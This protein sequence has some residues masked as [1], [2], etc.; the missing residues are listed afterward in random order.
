MGERCVV[1]W[2]NRS[3]R[4]EDNPALAEAARAGRVLP[5]TIESADGEGDWAPGFAWN[6]W[7]GRS[8]AAL[9]KDLARLGSRLVLRRG[10]SARTLL[11]A[12]RACGA[13]AVYWNRRFEP[14]ARL[15]QAKVQAALDAEGL[16]VRT[17]NAALLVEPWDIE[18]K[19]GGPYKVFTPF[20][21]ATLERLRDFSE[22][23]PAPRR[24]EPPTKPVKSL[25][26][27]ELSLP[28]D[29]PDDA[30]M[31]E[32]WTPG[33]AGARAALERF[34]DNA[35]ADY[36]EGRDRVDREGVSRLSP[37]LAHGEIGPRQIWRAVRDRV[38]RSGGAGLT[39][40][41]E[42]FLRQL[43]WREF[44]RHLLHHF[45][46]TP[47][48]P[49]QEKFN[50][51]PWAKDPEALE[52]WKEGRTGFPIIDAGMRQ[53]RQS[54]WMHNRARLLVASFLTKDL[55]V[56]WLEGARWFWERLVDAD[57][58]NNTLGWQWTA[59]C[60]ADAAP[61]FRIFN[62][63]TQAER[64]DPRGDY[65]RRWLPEGASPAIPVVDH[66]EA[67]QRALAAYERVKA[68]GRRA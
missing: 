67:R 21:R 58:A 60:G 50:A 31:G 43:V 47:T 65:V 20:Y 4:T 18:T 59:G 11:D 7:E 9:Q 2:M 1:V 41:A 33:E 22:P 37:H 23:I 55:L 52:A 42:A 39:A 49:L 53:L 3:L 16:E 15:A 24:L 30:R 45:P 66:A 57:L 17:F 12:A 28:R 6:W 68:A 48:E 62:P 63:T 36:H 27:D 5:I 64:F 34:L 10:E 44:A 40:G 46:H 35:A 13:D 61:Y 19:T 14:S 8:L 26:L 51:F 32:W 29:W 25:A 56:P 38:D 54:G